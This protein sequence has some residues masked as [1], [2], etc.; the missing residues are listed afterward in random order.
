M[1][2]ES[3]ARSRSAPEN[4][5]CSAPLRRWNWA[6]TFA[7]STRCICGT[8]H[9][10]L[11]ITH[12]RYFFKAKERMISGSVARPRFDLANREL[13]EAHLHSVW[14]QLVGLGLKNSVADVLDLDR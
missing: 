2:S 10:R 9:R 12:N 5:P 3:N 6:S 13:I 8:F 4:C 11:Q 14:M 7:I 1:T